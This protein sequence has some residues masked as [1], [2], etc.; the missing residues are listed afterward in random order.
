MAKA[1]ITIRQALQYQLHQDSWFVATAVLFNRISAFYFEVIQ[2]RQ[3]PH[4]SN[5]GACFR[6]WRGFVVQPI[7]QSLQ[8]RRGWAEALDVSWYRQ[9]LPQPAAL[10]FSV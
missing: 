2:A 5:A 3:R 9:V 8:A 10:S 6:S 4:A 7:C 1:T